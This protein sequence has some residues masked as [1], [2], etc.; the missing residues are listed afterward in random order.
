MRAI[1]FCLY[2]SCATL[3]AH[4]N[5]SVQIFQK[6]P[7]FE[8]ITFSFSEEREEVFLDSNTNDAV[9]TVF[10]KIF[11][12]IS[13]IMNNGNF[14]SREYTYIR[15]MN[16]KYIFDTLKKRT[17]KDGVRTHLSEDRTESNIFLDD[18]KKAKSVIPIGYKSAFIDTPTSCRAPYVTEF[19]MTYDYQNNIANL[20][21]EL[22]H[23]LK[24][25]KKEENG[26]EYIFFPD[27]GFYFD[28]KT[29]LLSRIETLISLDG[30]NWQLYKRIVFNKYEN[31]SGIYFPIDV[32]VQEFDSDIMV[33]NSIFKIDPESLKFNTVIEERINI[34]FPKGCF[35]NDSLINKKYISGETS[36]DEG[37]E[38]IMVDMLEATLKAAEEKKE[39]IKKANG[40]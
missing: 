38:I 26:R 18:E 4:E 24:F 9:L 3:M 28:S 37:K 10:S 11:G 35:V 33:R 2:F 16:G 29:L 31:I 19:W 1:F 21:F 25:E 40:K 20:F 32:N 6:M 22:I 7:R 15:D 12:D 14:I 27:L 30:T 13:Y 39:E 36:I 8:S 5:L 17:F 34:I 23:D